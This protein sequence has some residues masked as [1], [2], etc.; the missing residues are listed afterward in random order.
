[1]RSRVRFVTAG[2]V[3]RDNESRRM[4][5]LYDPAATLREAR[6][7]YF[8]KN[9]LADADTSKGSSQHALKPV[10]PGPGSWP[11]ARAL[12][13]RADADR[14]RALHHVVTD[15]DNTLA[16]E[17]A[18]AAWELASGCGTNLLAWAR[19]LRGILVGLVYHPRQMLRACAR[20]LHSR[21]LY[22]DA[23][24]GAGRAGR[25]L[26]EALL[27]ET[28]GSLRARLLPSEPVHVDARAWAA[29][30]GYGTAAVLFNLLCVLLVLGPVLLLVSA[31][32]G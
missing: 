28:V 25:P 6:A 12:G 7:L 31:L 14:L 23:R 22:G 9:G 5:T 24:S 18:L 15:Y 27:D 29:L 1:M 20:G 11:V 17:S 26:D 4:E 19:S 30:A 21:N 8:V 13:A 2:A 10:R 32:I 16:G 3:L